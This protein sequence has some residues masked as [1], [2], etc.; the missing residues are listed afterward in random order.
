M[1]LLFVIPNC[2]YVADFDFSKS[3]LSECPSNNVITNLF[4]ASFLMDEHT[5]LQD[6]DRV[7]IGSTVSFDHTFKIASNIGYYR[8]DKVWVTQYD[9]L[10]L[11]MN[12]NGQVVAWQFTKG[13]SFELVRNLLDGLVRHSHKQNQTVATVYVDDCCKLRKK[14]QSVFGSDT[15][16][17]LDLFHTVQRITKT[18]FKKHPLYHQCLFSLRQVFREH[19]DSG[20]GRSTETPSKEILQQK[21]EDFSSKWKG[22][23]I[24][25]QQTDAANRNL[26]KHIA[27]GCLSEIAPGDGTNRNERF[28]RF[29]RSFFNKS[30][31]GI[32]LAYALM[33]VLIHAHNS[34][35]CLK[36][37][38]ITTPISHMEPSNHC[39]TRPMG[40]VRKQADMEQG[41][42][43]WEMDLSENQL[44]MELVPSVFLHCLKKMRLFQALQEMKLC[45]HCNHIL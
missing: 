20:Q 38:R 8:N 1:R 44:D 34:S 13:T 17:K 27:S 18:F 39:Q 12:G 9:S 16:V 14:I 41:L 2:D 26:H 32:T 19:G 35:L 36:G 6:V 23:P 21:L 40:V 37:K 45:V 10:F 29:L 22:T 11:V 42:Q 30:K 24:W 28:H 4:V 25:T 5:Y 31:I 7:S 43:H 33:S 15:R 3:S